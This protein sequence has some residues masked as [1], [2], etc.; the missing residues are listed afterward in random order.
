MFYSLTTSALVLM[1][2]FV[3]S[4]VTLGTVVL[5]GYVVYKALSYE[6]GHAELALSG[7]FNIMQ[8]D[9]NLYN[10]DIGS[11]GY[12]QVDNHGLQ[13]MLSN[14]NRSSKVV[15]ETPSNA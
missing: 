9:K 8:L 11:G 5:S 14:N 3:G 12:I 4:T 2:S 13:Q 1:T 15:T 7:Q 6:Y 10:V